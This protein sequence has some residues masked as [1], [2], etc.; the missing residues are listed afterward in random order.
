[1]HFTDLFGLFQSV[2]YRLTVFNGFA[3]RCIFVYFIHAVNSV[4]KR[5]IRTDKRS[6]F[7]SCGNPS[8]KMRQKAIVIHKRI[9][10]FTQTVF[11]NTVRSFAAFYRDC[12]GCSDRLSQKRTGRHNAY[13]AHCKVRHTDISAG[14]EQVFDILGIKRSVRQTVRRGCFD[15]CVRVTAVVVSAGKMIVYRPAAVR[16]GIFKYAVIRYVAL[17]DHVFAAHSP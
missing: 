10:Q 8:C 9:L 16:N 13:T 11:V 6:I 2:F 1:M 15:V 4:A 17:C 7:A 5:G 3:A 12:R 14:K